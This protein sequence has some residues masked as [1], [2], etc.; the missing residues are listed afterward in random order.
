MLKN[1]QLILNI[2]LFRFQTQMD[3]TDKRPARDWP[4]YGTVG[5]GKGSEVRRGKI[6]MSS[7]RF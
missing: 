2:P 3:K 4:I 6:Y 1:D 7:G 5:R